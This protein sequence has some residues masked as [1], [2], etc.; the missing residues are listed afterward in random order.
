MKNSAIVNGAS[1]YPYTCSVVKY[2]AN[3]TV[4]NNPWVACVALFSNRPWCARVTAR[5]EAS[6]VA[7]FSKGTC[8][9]LNG[10]LP[11]CSQVYPSSIIGDSL[12]WCAGLK[13]VQTCT[14][15][16]HLH[17]VTYTRCRIDTINSPDDGHMDARNM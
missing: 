1:K 5:P 11:V 4:K 10:W 2:K 9:G 6:R 7:V 12:E 16:G 13:E 14:P 15:D 17:R 3:N 8:I